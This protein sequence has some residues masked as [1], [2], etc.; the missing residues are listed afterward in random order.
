MQKV[1]NLWGMFCLVA[2][3]SL[4][5]SGCGGGGGSSSDDTPPETMEPMEPEGPTQAEMEAADAAATAATEAAAA[6]QA[7]IDAATLADTTAAEEAAAAATAAAAAVDAED[8]A[9]VA[10]ANE[11]AAAANDAASALEMAEAAAQEQ[12]EADRLAA[13]A[14][15][16]AEAERIAGLIGPDATL[17]DANTTTASADTNESIVTLVQPFSG[18]NFAEVQFQ[19]S[20]TVDDSPVVDMPEFEGTGHPAMID[21]WTGGVYTHTSEDGNTVHTVTKYNDKAADMDEAYS[22]FFTNAASTTHRAGVAVSSQTNGVLD[23]DEADVNGNHELFA[24]TTFPGAPNTTTSHTGAQS[25]TGAFRGI[26][27]IFKCGD[28]CTSTKNMDGDLSGLSDGWTFVPTVID[29]LDPTDTSEGGGLAMINEA[30][31]ALMVP[32]VKQDADFMIF[33]YWEHS[34]TDAEG[35]TTERMLPF[36]DG[37]RDFGDLTATADRDNNPDT[38]ATAVLGTARYEGPATGLYMRKT[39]T[40]QGLVDQDG[41]FTSGQFTA[42]AILTANFGGDDVAV[43]NQFSIDGTI[44]NFMDGDV[45]IDGDWVVNL[46]RPEDDGSTAGTNESR[47]IDPD[48]GTFTG[49][50]DGGTLDDP[51]NVGDWS[52]TF[53]GD[54]TAAHPASAS[55]IFDAH[56]RNGHVRG[57]FAVD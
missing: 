41:P 8:P 12:A 13:H 53:H 30:L 4:V 44:S 55:G 2:V 33:G 17:A 57:A 49:V 1:K 26:S 21:G 47:N 37:K 6:A 7:A 20:A 56:F 24:G 48:A 54:S 22:T 31:M 11:A 15:D 27:G 52:G 28:S 29:G 3:L 32:G 42:D 34:F 23:I 10:A 45:T 38:A 43:N 39:I 51:A 18:E 19:T 14:A 25:I 35:E 40:S 36:A 46:N 5:M 50:T 9:T 16:K